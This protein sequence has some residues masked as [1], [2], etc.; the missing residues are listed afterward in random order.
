MSM[1]LLTMKSSTPAS[2]RQIQKLN[3]KP[4]L[5]RLSLCHRDT[6]AR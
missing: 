1:F 2:V 5:T 6:E 4:L 3:A